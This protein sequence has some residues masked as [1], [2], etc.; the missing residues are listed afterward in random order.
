MSETTTLPDNLKA[1][2]ARLHFE[3]GSFKNEQNEN[4]DYETLYLTISVKGEEVK[5]K[6][7]VEKSDKL[8]IKLADVVEQPQLGEE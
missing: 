2:I 4:I 6:L 8:L 1:R 3:K 7:P 5:I